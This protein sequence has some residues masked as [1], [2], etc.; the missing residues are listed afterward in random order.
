MA[1]GKKKLLVC[2][3]AGEE[4]RRR[5]SKTLVCTIAVSVTLRMVVWERG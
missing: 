5:L 1:R 2:T 3:K 4:F